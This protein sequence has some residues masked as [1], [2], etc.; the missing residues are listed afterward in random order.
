MGLRLYEGERGKFKGKDSQIH[1]RREDLAVL[2][3]LAKS[4]FRIYEENILRHVI[5]TKGY[6]GFSDYR[7]PLTVESGYTLRFRYVNSMSGAYILGNDNKLIYPN[8]VGRVMFFTSI[9]SAEKHRKE[10]LR[11]TSEL[12]ERYYDSSN[13]SSDKTR[14]MMEAFSMGVI[15]DLFS[16]VMN[17]DPWILEVT[18]AYR[19][20][21]MQ[22]AKVV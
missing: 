10:L 5:I 6:K 22:K 11:K 2:N 17:G 1:T 8:G 3:V 7:F 21:R 16:A 14:I 13:T 18:P 9:H 19:S 20:S 12:Y 15:S 4:P